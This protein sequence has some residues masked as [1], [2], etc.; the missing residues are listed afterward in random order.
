MKVDVLNIEGKSTGRSVDLPDAIF[1]IEPNEHAVY[2][3]VKLYNNNQRQGTSKAK[4][5]GEIKGSTRKIKKQKGTGT[6][7]AG[8]IKNP[9]FKGG[10]RVFGPKPRDYKMKV[11][12][13]VKRIAKLSALSSKVASGEL[14]V[15]EDFTFDAPEVKSFKNILNNLEIGNKKS[16]IVTGDYDSNLY[17]S[18]RNLAKSSVMNAKDLNTYSI[19]NANKVLIS[20]SAVTKMTELLA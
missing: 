14:A 8:S 3:A 15:I 7:R 11:N 6:A 12:K 10:G 5:R 18:C 2:L 1:G 13:K 19:L 16:L 9:L 17:L 20:E 4:E